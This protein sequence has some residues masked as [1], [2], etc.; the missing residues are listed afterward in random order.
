MKKLLLYLMILLSAQCLGQ[1]YKLFNATSKKLFGNLP[2]PESTYSLS[3]E[4]ANEVGADSVYYNFFGLSSVEFISDTCEFWGGPY[5]KQQNVP[6][7]AGKKIEF[8]NKYSYYFFNLNNDTLT[9]SFDKELD[10]PVPFFRDS[11]QEFS[12]FYEKDDTL[13]V[14]N[15]PDSA[16]IFR[17]AHTDLDGNVIDSQLNGEHIIISKKFGLTQFFVI[18]SFPSVLKPL[19]LLGNSNPDAGFYQLTSE[20]VYNYQPGDEVQ[21]N[22][23]SHYEGYQPPWLTFNRYRK[24]EFLERKE[25]NDSLIYKVKQEIFYIDSA[26]LQTDTITKRYLRSKVIAQ[27]PFEKFDWRNRR[28]YQAGY[29]GQIRWTYS[30]DSYNDATYCAADTCWGSRDVP[31]PPEH[32]VTSTV[33]GLGIYDDNRYVEGLDGYHIHNKI[34]Y[35]KK[36][37][38]VCGNEVVMSIGEHHGFKHK[39]SLSPNPASGVVQIITSGEPIK[40]MLIDM[41]GNVRLIRFT[42]ATE[43]SLDVSL[44]N[45]GLYF[46]KV[47]MKDG[48]LVNRKLI[49]IKK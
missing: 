28:L 3:I 48:G 6:V 27:I 16:R 32:R 18:D 39:I 2:V 44:L 40:I 1:N 46:V 21:F 30:T 36:D 10:G 23:K 19:T 35:F 43:L 37:T 14:L 12:L 47:L 7:W 33:F 38:V 11:I 17:I 24:L 49:V 34:V 8:N 4:S 41:T 42:S 25:T 26:G 31:G 22:E 15:K 45:D 13:T 5:C 20:M 9:F 29:C